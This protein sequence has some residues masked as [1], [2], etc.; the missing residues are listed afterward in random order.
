MKDDKYREL[1]VFSYRIFYKIIENE[2]VAI[3]GVVHGQRLFDS[4]WIE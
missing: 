4:S 1:K 3:I 2:K